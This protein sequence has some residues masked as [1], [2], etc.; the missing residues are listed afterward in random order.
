[1]VSGNVKNTVSRMPVQTVYGRIRI[2]PTFKEHQKCSTALW[3]HVC[4]KAPRWGRK[5]TLEISST[6]SSPSSSCRI[7]NGG[8]RGMKIDAS[9]AIETNKTQEVQFLVLTNVVQV[10]SS[11]C[12]L[13][14]WPAWIHLASAKFQARVKNHEIQHLNR[15]SWHLVWILADELSR[16]RWCKLNHTAVHNIKA[17]PLLRFREESA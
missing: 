16:D 5:P 7:P 4:I 12:L 10:T 15:I 8:G 14:E 13:F 11:S 17:S 6:S 2:F 3:H 9:M 1:M